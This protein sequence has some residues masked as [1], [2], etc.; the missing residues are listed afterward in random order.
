MVVRIGTPGNDA[1]QG[2]NVAD[3]LSGEGGDDFLNGLRGNDRLFGG[4]GIDF[5][6]GGPGNDTIIGAE[7]VD[8]EASYDDGGGTRG[9]VADLGAGRATDNYGNTDTLIGIERLRGSSFGDTLTGDA[10][11]NNLQGM[12]GNDTLFGGDGDDFGLDGGAGNDTI[13]GGNGFDSLRFRDLLQTGVV[14]NLATGVVQ[15]GQGGIDRIFGVES[16]RDSALDDTLIGD[17]LNNRFRIELGGSNT[18]QG[19][20]GSDTLDYRSD[21][22]SIVANL[23][24]GIVNRSDGETDRVSGIENVVGS[25]RNDTITGGGSADFEAFEGNA[26]DDVLDGRSGFD[27]AAYDREEGGGAIVVDLR[28]GTAMDTFGDTD[29]LI[30]IEEIVATALDDSAR[31][32]GASFESFRML[33][34]DDSVDGRGGIDRIDFSRDPDGVF[35][36]LGAGIARDGFGGL[37]RLANVEDVRGSAFDDFLRGNNQGN[38]L[39]GLAGNDRLVGGSDEDVL[40]GD[41]GF[42]ILAGGLGADQLWGGAAR[43]RF[44]FAALNEGLDSIH[45]FDSQDVLDLRRITNASFDRGDPV[46]QFVR[47]VPQ[48]GDTRVLVDADGNGT[49]FTTLAIL[50]GVTGLTVAELFAEGR[51]LLG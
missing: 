29:T 19:G 24:A 50:D 43:D 16:V 20:A 45:D 12:A 13:F 32:S 33:A 38:R 18:I 5:I 44:E 37:D 9:V 35:V 22:I 25:S 6:I 47:L 30:G 27:R 17:D 31:G 23:Q 51:L 39:E 49:G 3:T 4:F 36:N 2:T 28:A 42:D 40:L 46:G 21:A 48:A 7:D 26:G 1:L 10:G 11:E 34:G 14:V 15:D 41:S 8:D